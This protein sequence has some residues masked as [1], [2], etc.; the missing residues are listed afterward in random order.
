M[1][2]VINFY[3]CSHFINNFTFIIYTCLCIRSFSVVCC[4]Q[5]HVHKFW[6]ACISNHLPNSFRTLPLFFLLVHCWVRE[7]N[8]KFDL[9]KNYFDKIQRMCALFS[10][11]RIRLNS[12]KKWP[13][14][15]YS[16][17]GFSQ[18]VE[19]LLFSFNGL[20]INNKTCS[21]KVWGLNLLKILHHCPRPWSRRALCK[22]WSGFVFWRKNIILF[23]QQNYQFGIYLSLNLKQRIAIHQ[24]NPAN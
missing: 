9:F 1:S 5:H 22:I 2:F 19:F 3:Q 10:R 6:L 13:W 20:R 17:V 8:I 11:N 18:H 7:H 21:S 24:T 4:L 15:T 12:F 23:M 14:T 16:N